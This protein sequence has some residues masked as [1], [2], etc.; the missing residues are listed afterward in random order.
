MEEAHK[1]EHKKSLSHFFVVINART[2]YIRYSYRMV[3]F[4]FAWTAGRGMMKVRTD[5]T[6]S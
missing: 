6:S 1:S 4:K 5:V 3:D 2:T